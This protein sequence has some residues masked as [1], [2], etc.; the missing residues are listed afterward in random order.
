PLFSRADN[1]GQAK[2]NLAK[3]GTSKHSSADR[4]PHLKHNS[5]QRGEHN[6]TSNDPKN[7]QNTPNFAPIS[8]QNVQ[9]SAVGVENAAKNEFKTRKYVDFEILDA[10]GLV[11]NGASK[12]EQGERIFPSLWLPK[13]NFASK[14]QPSHKANDAQSQ[15]YQTIEIANDA[16]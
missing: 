10:S 1:Q 14:S 11:G 13:D 8:A 5:N 3:S 6:H 4:A 7:V 15:S 12:D 2:R 16:A 9:N